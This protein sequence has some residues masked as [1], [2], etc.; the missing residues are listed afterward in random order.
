MRK[1]VKSGAWW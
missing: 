1:H